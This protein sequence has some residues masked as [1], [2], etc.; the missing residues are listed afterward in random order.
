MSFIEWLQ[1]H[2]IELYHELTNGWMEAM[3][4]EE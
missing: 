3:E 1:N 2:D 4:E